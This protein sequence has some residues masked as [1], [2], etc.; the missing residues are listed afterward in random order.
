[1]KVVELIWFQLPQGLRQTHASTK[2]IPEPN[3]IIRKRW[4]TQRV[5]PAATP[6]PVSEIMNWVRLWTKET[7]PLWSLHIPY[8]TTVSKFLLLPLQRLLECVICVLKIGNGTS[9]KL[10]HK[11]SSS[12]LEATGGRC[13]QRR[14]KNTTKL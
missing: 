6:I 8:S 13:T 5:A 14:R 7:S 3:I 11:C 1:L 2:N 12:T 4:S 9:C 10:V